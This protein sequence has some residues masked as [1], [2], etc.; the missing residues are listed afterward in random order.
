MQSGKRKH[1]PNWGGARANSGR[2]KKT[3]HAA[4]EAP[5]GP[6]SQLILPTSSSSAPAHAADAQVAPNTAFQLPGVNA[7]VFFTPRARN[8]PAP[9]ASLQSA[10][11]HHGVHGTVS[12]VG[13][14]VL[15]ASGNS[16]MFTCITSPTTV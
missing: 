12:G 2:K 9:S 16:G 8:R 10:S 13:V 7:G 5:P 4:A 3:K 15:G 14:D 6:T 11:V 1:T